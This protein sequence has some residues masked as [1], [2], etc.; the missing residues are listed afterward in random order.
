MLRSRLLVNL[1]VG[2]WYVLQGVLFFVVRPEL[3][4]SYG[5]WLHP[6][7]GDLPG[8]TAALTLPVLGPE[9][10]SAA[11]GYSPVFWLVWGALL[12]PPVRLLHWA[13][14]APNRFALLETTLYWT[15]AYLLA[16]GSLAVLVVLG[17]WLP[18]STA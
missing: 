14:T 5:H 3:A 10:S 9:I 13:W 6:L 16:T 1:V 2:L 17:L 7:R 11:E 15:A 18:F 12:L 4:Y 8:L